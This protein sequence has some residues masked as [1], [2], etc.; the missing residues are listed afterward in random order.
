MCVTCCRYCAKPQPWRPLAANVQITDGGSQRNTTNGKK[1]STSNNSM[2]SNF[3]P[4]Q[5]E[6]CQNV[7]NLPFV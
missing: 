4:L 3:C 2:M 5:K 7:C 6:F 1:V